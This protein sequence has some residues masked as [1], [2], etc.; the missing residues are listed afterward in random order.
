MRLQPHMKNNAVVA[1]ADVQTFIRRTA[2]AVVTVFM[3]L[4]A[5]SLSIAEKVPSKVPDAIA[6]PAGS[7]L[8]LVA[9]A[10]GSQIYTCQ[11]TAD[12]K[13][14]WSLKAP[15]AELRDDNGKVIGHHAAGPSWM[16]DDG[17]KITGKA[18]GHADSPDP[19]S[20]PW[21]LVNVVAH[22][23]NGQ[24]A[25]V[26][27]IQRLNTHGGKAPAGGCDESHK[28]AETRASYGADYYFYSASK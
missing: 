20:I 16:L 14:A 27:L 18:A 17:S 12:G 1:E 7:T 13:F 8:L 24:L 19:D 15:D 3:I 6:V 23:G 5:T 21:L 26:S 9:H 11:A 2:A 25:G 22:E 4:A 10:K 28:N